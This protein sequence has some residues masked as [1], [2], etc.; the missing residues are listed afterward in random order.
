MLAFIFAP[1]VV[2]TERNFFCQVVSEQEEVESPLQLVTPSSLAV[3]RRRIKSSHP[4]KLRK[5]WMGERREKVPG[6]VGP[7]NRQNPH[8]LRAFP[9]VFQSP[10]DERV[11]GGGGKGMVCSI[12]IFREVIWETWVYPS[13]SPDKIKR[14]ITCPVISIPRIYVGNKFCGE[15]KIR[16]QLFS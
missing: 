7:A 1:M 11:G 3:S 14:Q 6:W 10:S 12:I 16:E 5:A 9:H 4:T 2:Y 8:L 13:V 15:E